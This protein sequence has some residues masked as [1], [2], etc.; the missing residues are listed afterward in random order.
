MRA[1]QKLGSPLVPFP[2]KRTGTGHHDREKTDVFA[3]AS[4]IREL[5]ETNSLASVRQ[6]LPSQVFDLLNSIMVQG[7]APVSAKECE[8][9]LL[10]LLRMAK[11]ESYHNLHGASE[12]IENRFQKAVRSAS[13][14]DELY[15]M[16]K[17]KRYP[18]SRVR[19]LVM[20]AFIGL[21]AAKAALPP[22][23]VRVL[24]LNDQGRRFLTQAKPK[25]PLPILTKP[26]DIKRLSSAAQTLF[27]LECRATDLHA[28]LSPTI[29]PCG[30]DY[31][32]SPL[33]IAE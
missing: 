26:A 3:S 15:F 6:L 19:R 22:Q 25:C 28:S 17:T 24:A 30:L 8:R 12:G 4:Y 31:T 9:I 20:A 21:D 11:D 10:S 7:H 1:I 27:A 32:T 14:L 18:L 29:R 16:I 2:V 23:Y 33:F 13:T 5:I